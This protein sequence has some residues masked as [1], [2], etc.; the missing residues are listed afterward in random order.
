M[1]ASRVQ[2]PDLGVTSTAAHP[3]ATPRGHAGPQED[4]FVCTARGHSRS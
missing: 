3:P 1:P 2:V 4:F